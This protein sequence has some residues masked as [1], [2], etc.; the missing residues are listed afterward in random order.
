MFL[1]GRALPSPAL[2]SLELLPRGGSQSSAWSMPAAQTHRCCLQECSCSCSCQSQGGDL[3]WTKEC[4]Q[5]PKASCQNSATNL[6]RS[7]SLKVPW[8]N[9]HG[10]ASIPSLLSWNPTKLLFVSGCRTSPFQHFWHTVTFCLPLWGER[11]GFQRALTN[12]F[13]QI[14]P[15]CFCACPYPAPTPLPFSFLLRTHS[16]Q[17]SAIPLW[18]CHSGNL[19]TQR[20]SEFIFSIRVGLSV[21]GI[22]GNTEGLGG[23]QAAAT[24]SEEEGPRDV[25]LPGRIYISTADF[26]QH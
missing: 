2:H 19:H 11:N 7:R 6:R 26:Q 8:D 17:I 1:L 15:H 5:L 22:W 21:A 10:T 13:S 12:I 20:S 14:L 24:D 23:P 9:I 16:K 25:C 3:R 18:C 4:Q